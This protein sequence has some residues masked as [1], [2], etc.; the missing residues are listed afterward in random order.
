MNDN[1][2]EL[3]GDSFRAAR[4]FARVQ[5]TFHRS[6]PL[7]TLFHSPTVATLAKV[8]SEAGSTPK[9]LVT[10]QHGSSRPPLFCIHGQSGSVLMYRS[11]AQH[12]GSEQ[13]VYGVQPPGPESNG[14]RFTSIEEMASTY[15][16]EVEL[17]QGE[18]PYFLA[19]YCM[20]G[21]IAF[22]MAQ[23]LRRHGH[24]VG[25]VALLD[26]Y[27]WG[28]TPTSKPESLYFTL[29]TSWFGLRHFLFLDAHDKRKFLRRSYEELWNEESE[30][31]EHNKRAAMTYVPK[32]YAGR[33]LHV[34]PTRQLARYTTAGTKPERPGSTG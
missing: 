19:G 11:L 7:G 8:I 13:P 24:S 29:Q 21:T 5:E 10:I 2:F 17:I 3:G 34:R 15:V 12:M 4:L 14:S 30:L 31:A 20:G 27:N 6:V 28:R 16:R 25:L 23:Q 9:C 32:V 26:T 22:E 18:G 1:F 33:I